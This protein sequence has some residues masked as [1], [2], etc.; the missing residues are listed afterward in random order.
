MGLHTFFFGLLLLAFNVSQTILAQQMA[1][2]DKQFAFKLSALVLSTEIA[3]VLIASFSIL[4]DLSRTRGVSKKKFMP[5]RRT[6]LVMFVPAL[7][8]T[9]SNTLLYRTIA[10]MGST[11]SQ[12]WSNMRIVVTASLCRILVPRQLSVLQWM[13]LFLL[14]VG[15]LS[16]RD[17]V[18]AEAVPKITPWSIFSSLT[19]T[20]SASLA[21]VYQE[22]LFK[23]DN[24]ERIAVKSLA[25]YLWTCILAFLQWWFEVKGNDRPFFDGFTHLTW[26]SLLLSALYGQAVAL[27]LFYCDNLVKVFA[28]SLGP[29]AAMLLDA[30]FLGGSVRFAQVLGAIVVLIST[31]LFYSKQSMLFMQDHEALSYMLS[32]VH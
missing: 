25:L 10:L 2:I 24:E 28:T 30:M 19:Q 13:S 7:L 17:D 5:T 6:L 32:N 23:N 1:G 15:V 14:L 21:G 4:Y 9:I 18:A 31:V 8:Y 11:N 29:I 27:T 12:V 3:K 20:T 16:C 26:L 22:V